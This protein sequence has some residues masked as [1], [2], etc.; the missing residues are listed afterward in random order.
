ME[1]WLTL[2]F[3]SPTQLPPLVRAAEAAGLTGVT[4]PEHVVV[5]TEVASSYPYGDGVVTIP[6][7]TP[8]ADPLVL[9]AALA[10]ATTRLRFMTHVLL[11]PLRHPLLLAKEV[12]TAATLSGGRLDL[13]VGVGWLA[14]EFDALDV[15]FAERGSRSEEAIPLLRRLWT[16]VPVVHR[17]RHFSFGSVEVQP[18][19]PLPMRVLV[20]GHSAVAVE[21]AARIGDG[22]VGVNPTVE[23]LSAVLDQ[24]RAARL[25]SGR[26]AQPFLVRTGVRGRLTDE[27]VEAL[28]ALG[29]DALIVTPWQVVPEGSAFDIDPRA[30]ADALPALVERCP[31]S[32][33]SPTV[34]TT[35]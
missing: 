24:L 3:L 5:P 11:L 23:E 21:R 27:K 33:T 29:V 2:P 31:G 9:V 30:L 26:A 6:P 20:G 17:G 16:G 28:R 19:P 22:W 35:R 34:P 7:G 4:V 25:V 10:A 15:P 14:E 12:A 8:F 13:G 1:V 18:R 32:P